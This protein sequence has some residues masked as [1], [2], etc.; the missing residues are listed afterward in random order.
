MWEGRE[1][2][3]L[4]RSTAFTVLPASPT[5]APSQMSIPKLFLEEKK[6]VDRLL[7]YSEHFSIIYVRFLFLNKFDTLIN[8]V[9]TIF[10]IS[11]RLP[12]KLDSNQHA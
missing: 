8:Y 9:Y 12:K 6:I 4:S 2:N 3:P 7:C 1:S 10:T 5:A 11:G